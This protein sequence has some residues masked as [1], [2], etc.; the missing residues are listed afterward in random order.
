MKPTEKHGPSD[1]CLRSR[2]VCRPRKPEALIIVER[3]AT[4]TAYLKKAAEYFRRALEVDPENALPF[5]PGKRA[6]RNGTARKPQGDLR[7]A[8]RLQP[9]Y[10]DAHYNLAFVC[11]K[12]GAYAEHNGT[13]KSVYHAGPIEP[14][15]G[16]A[17]QRLALSETNRPAPHNGGCAGMSETEAWFEPSRGVARNVS[18]SL[19]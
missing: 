15:V 18:S 9:D 11:E 4:R 12:L 6:G 17:R 5:Q 16:Y 10:P 8:V 14:L 2:F 13:G 3:S 19:I 1:R 7:Q